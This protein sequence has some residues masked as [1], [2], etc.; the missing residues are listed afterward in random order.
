MLSKKTI[1]KIVDCGDSQGADFSE[2]FVE[3]SLSSSINM[4]DQKIDEI[5]SL[6]SFGIGVRLIYMGQAYYGYS[7]DPKE[8]NLIKLTK[9]LGKFREDF[10][11]RQTKMFNKQSF[12]D[13][14]HIAINPETVCKSERVTLLRKINE[15]TR[16]QGSSIKQVRASMVEKK[17]VIL[18]ANSEGLWTEDTRNYSRMGLS[19]VAEKK[20]GPQTASDS[21][22]VLGGYEFFKDLDLR[23]FLQN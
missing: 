5:S 13:N 18:I 12:E 11:S 15:L 22:G 1:S 6:N 8:D 23:Q 2:V 20:D 4:L 3:E 17:R 21:P 10:K 7:S 9:N 16:N 19:A 14:H